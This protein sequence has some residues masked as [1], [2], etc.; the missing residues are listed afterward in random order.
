MMFLAVPVVGAGRCARGARPHHRDHEP[1]DR[2]PSRPSAHCGSP[3]RSPFGRSVRCSGDLRTRRFRRRRCRCTSIWL[4]PRVMWTPGARRLIER[5][6]RP[7]DIGQGEVPW[8]VLAD[9]E[10]NELCR[11][12]QTF[13]DRSGTRTYGPPRCLPSE[14][15]A[16]PRSRGRPGP[17]PRRV[18][19]RREHFGRRP[20][21]FRGAPLVEQLHVHVRASPRSR[22]AGVTRPV[23]ASPSIGASGARAR[24]E[25]V[26]PAGRT[27]RQQADDR[28]GAA[29]RPG[30]RCGDDGRRAWC[31]GARRGRRA[32]QRR[33]DGLR[34]WQQHR[35]RGGPGL[36]SG[37]EL[38]RRRSAADPRSDL[39]AATVG[40]RTFLVGGYDGS[41]IRA[42]A[43]ATTDGATFALL[44]DLPVPV[45]YPAV[46]AVGTDVY[47]I[48]GSDRRRR[49][50][51]GPGARHDDGGGARDRGSARHPVRCGRRDRRRARVRVRR[52]V[53][54]S[55]VGAG[56]AARRRLGSAP[57]A[58]LTPVATLATPVV[59][60]AVAVLGDRAYLVGGES[61]AMLS[62][63]SVLEVR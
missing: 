22:R 25:R 33:A 17:R 20:D 57:S 7:V 35:D 9:P 16:L 3:R 13:S 11:P 52:R 6:A 4:R 12:L 38:A 32:G 37:R 62:T 18:R 2:E 55:T 5:G 15:S 54:R 26:A 34:R 46:A 47:V 23:A 60:A 44:G 39:A 19:Q 28:R 48:G 24:R 30:H 29:S 53:G 42:T 58:R 14:R 50:A 51:D 21:P 27:R 61:P 36:R 31:R 8:V 1:H 43:L 40:A 59:D 56:L 45:R 63:V 49:G 41:S 10:G